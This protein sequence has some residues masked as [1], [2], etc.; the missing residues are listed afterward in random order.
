MKNTRKYN[1]TYADGGKH[2]DAVIWG[3]ALRE[4]E[5][6][7]VLG[8]GERHDGDGAWPDDQALRPQP[9]KPD[10]GAQRV[11]DVGVVTARLMITN[12][13]II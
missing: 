3:L 6:D 9:H 12:I 1:L 4:D 10:E 13:T 11:Q 8:E 2:P 5:L 7:A